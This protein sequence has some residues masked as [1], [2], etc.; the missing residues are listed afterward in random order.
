[1]GRR[2]ETLLDGVLDAPTF[3]A[4]ATMKNTLKSSELKSNE[5][6]CF[7]EYRKKSA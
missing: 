2:V 1:M 3:D 7:V 6:L 5:F 4:R